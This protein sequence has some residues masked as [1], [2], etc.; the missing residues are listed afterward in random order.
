MR[1]LITKVYTNIHFI[2]SMIFEIAKGEIAQVNRNQF[3]LTIC[4][5]HY[6]VSKEVA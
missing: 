3:L 4:D 2:H 5:H 1:K 6:V